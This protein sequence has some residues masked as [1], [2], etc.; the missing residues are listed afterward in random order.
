MR[1]P[2]VSTRSRTSTSAPARG[3]ALALR[4][5]LRLAPRLVP[6]WLEPDRAELGRV[7]EELAARALARSGWRLQG[8]RLR[9]RQG[10]VDLWATRDEV[11]LVVEVKTGRLPYR[12]GREPE[13]DLRW[14]PGHSL[15]PEQR[16]R[17]FRAARSLA[18]GAGGGSRSLRPEVALVEVLVS[19][20]GGTLRVL[21]PRRL[22]TGEQDPYTRRQP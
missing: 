22:S 12:P 14:R 15:G 18:R 8:R 16:R 21:P 13:W 4:I 2:G 5:L 20:D 6:R 7:G 11:S 10:E 9:T 1:P 3:R 17:L 19:R